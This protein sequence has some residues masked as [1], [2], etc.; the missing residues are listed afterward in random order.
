MLARRLLTSL[1]HWLEAASQS[2]RKVIDRWQKLS[3]QLG[4]RV[5]LVSN[6]KRFTGN[7]VGIDPEKGLIVQLDSGGVRMFDAAHTSIMK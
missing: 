3:L 5:T 1:D 2:S 6:G 4:H 7:C